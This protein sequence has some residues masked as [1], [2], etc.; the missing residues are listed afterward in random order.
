MPELSVPALSFPGRN[1]VRTHAQIIVII[2]TLSH[3]RGNSP[4]DKPESHDNENDNDRGS[5]HGAGAP[6]NDKHW[7]KINKTWNRRRIKGIPKHPRKQ[8]AHW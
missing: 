7:V 5:Q 1:K 2:T 8:D 4:V 6:G 3:I